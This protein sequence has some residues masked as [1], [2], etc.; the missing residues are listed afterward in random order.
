MYDVFLS[1]NRVQKPWVRCLYQFLV[2]RGMSVFFD[3]ESIAPGANIVSEI[4]DALQ[5]SRHVL[6]AVSP[7]SLESRWVAME[8]Q[9]TIHDDCSADKGKLIPVVIEPV[10]FE[11]MRLSV[12][13]LNC[14][15]LTDA[16]SRELRLRFLLRHLGVSD[17]D[18][19]AREDILPLLSVSSAEVTDNVTVAGIRE[20]LD[21]GWDGVRLLDAFIE[22]DY[23][24]LEGLTAAHEGDSAQWAP[25]FMN[26][27]DTWRM[28]INGPQKIVGYWHFAPLFPDDYELA[29]KGILLD[30]HITPDRVR[31]FEL[32]GHYQVYFV[33]IC[34]HPSFRRPRYVRLLFD[35]VFLVLDSLSN[36]GVFIDEVCAN[37]YTSVGRSL[38]KS[39][40]LKY[41][42]QHSEHGAIYAA[43]MKNVLSSSFGGSFADLRERYRQ[44]GLV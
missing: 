21:W 32:P 23:Q 26:H 25:V 30:S 16:G 11:A 18:T 42:C 12:R 41:L 38:C 13:S 31:L 34:L 3:E 5:N 36:D 29:K 20:T 22:L 6:L 27:S 24:T 15:D 7:K 19:V 28:L 17:A 40:Q 33:Q 37:A 10:N 8:T 43:P 9:L 4:E 2:K 1:H 39:F 14:V 35:S 44:R